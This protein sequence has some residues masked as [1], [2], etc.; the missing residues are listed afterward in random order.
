M[1]GK[2]VPAHAAHAD[3]GV[4]AWEQLVYRLHA[5]SPRP[6]EDLRPFT[7]GVHG[8]AAVCMRMRP[9]DDG[10]RRPLL[11]RLWRQLQPFT[12]GQVRSRVLLC[13]C[14]PV[15]LWVKGVRLCGSARC[16]RH[17]HDCMALGPDSS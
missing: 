6:G 12:E 2:T 11:R 5:L 13:P 1:S 9:N 3:R 17:R 10:T 14:A 7:A 8:H 15:P 4:A 16:P